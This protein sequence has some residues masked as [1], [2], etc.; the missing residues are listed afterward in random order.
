MSNEIRKKKAQELFDRYLKPGAPNEINVSHTVIMNIKNQID[1]LGDDEVLPTNLFNPATHQ[2]LILMQS[3]SYERFRRSE[4]FERMLLRLTPRDWVH[5]LHHPYKSIRNLPIE[6][7]DIGEKLTPHH[8]LR[9]KHP[10]T[11]FLGGRIP[12]QLYALVDAVP[13]TKVE[14][15]NE[16]FVPPSSMQRSCSY[17][18][19]Y[20]MAQ[21]EEKT[22]EEKKQEQKKLEEKKV[23]TVKVSSSFEDSSPSS[24][25]SSVNSLTNFNGEN[26]SP[27]EEPETIPKKG[28]AVALGEGMKKMRKLTGKGKKN[29]PLEK[30]VNENFSTLPRNFG[31]TKESSK[32]ASS[33][34][35]QDS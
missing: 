19:Q 8:G 16:D 20:E 17:P 34:K 21:A 18:E 14:E 4:H 25:N 28:M 27:T 13:K 10:N 26:P 24:F 3:D 1:T 33:T 5:L 31:K 23:P 30:G 6:A 32:Q 35:N 12:R 2:I 7:P 29:K 11:K 15:E 9:N 22:Q